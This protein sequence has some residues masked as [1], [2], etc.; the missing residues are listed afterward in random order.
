MD[1]VKCHGRR[2][3]DEGEGFAEGEGRNWE[4]I[5]LMLSRL[6]VKLV[7]I[8]RSASTMVSI[9]STP[10]VAIKRMSYP[11]KKSFT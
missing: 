2:A 1:G 8:R 7:T 3:R 5:V 9:A 6:L 4:K 11:H 10:I